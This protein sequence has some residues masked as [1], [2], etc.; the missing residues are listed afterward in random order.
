[1]RVNL[2]GK[3]CVCLSETL[4]EYSACHFLNRFLSMA[5]TKETSKSTPHLP[6][7]SA[8]IVDEVWT[9]VRI[10]STIW[11]RVDCI[12]ISRHQNWVYGI[13]THYFYYFEAF[14]VEYGAIGC[15]RR[16]GKMPWNRFCYP[17]WTQRRAPDHHPEAMGAFAYRCAKRITWC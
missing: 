8:S 11:L 2:I 5:S 6:L 13:N 10:R 7:P 3:F 17:N 14:F 9:R 1:M 12:H 4:Q 15:F 16:P